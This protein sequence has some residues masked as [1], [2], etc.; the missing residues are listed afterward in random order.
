MQRSKNN[1]AEENRQKIVGQLEEA[2]NR[3]KRLQQEEKTIKD[4]NQKIAEER[5]KLVGANWEK[6]KKKQQPTLFSRLVINK[7]GR[8]NPVTIPAAIGFII[9]KS[10]HT[11]YNL[12]ENLFVWLGMSFIFGFAICYPILYLILGMPISKN[13]KKQEQKRYYQEV[14]V[15]VNH[16]KAQYPIL[17]NKSRDSREQIAADFRK[18]LPYDLSVYQLDK[19]LE[20]MYRSFFKYKVTSLEK[21]HEDWKHGQLIAAGYS[22]Y[23]FEPYDNSSDEYESNKYTLVKENTQENTYNSFTNND[24]FSKHRTDNDEEIVDPYSADGRRKKW[25]EEQARQQKEFAEIVATNARKFGEDRDKVNFYDDLAGRSSY[26]RQLEDRQWDYHKDK[27]KIR[28][29]I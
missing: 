8:I 5:D 3:L 10:L 11:G 1:L 7:E 14:E 24:S 21:A 28:D 19:C 16:L 18:I 6:E 13:L 9:T 25:E 27:D 17:F 23:T 20:S 15:P 12:F 26:E 4:I 2:M 29:P 22:P